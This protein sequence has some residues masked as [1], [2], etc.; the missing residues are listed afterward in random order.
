MNLLLARVQIVPAYTMGR[1]YVNGEPEC[2]VLEDPVRDG[3]KVPGETAI[4]FG[5][6]VITID[7]SNRFKREMPTIKLST[8]SGKSPEFLEKVK[9]QDLGYSQLLSSLSRLE[10]VPLRVNPGMLAWVKRYKD[11]LKRLGV[12][13]TSSVIIPDCPLPRDLKRQD[14]TPMELQKLEEW[15]K[16]KEAALVLRRCH[17]PPHVPHRAR[18]LVP[19]AGAAGGHPQCAARGAGEARA[20]G[21]G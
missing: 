18:G 13:A 1:L 17:R 19:Q 14:M 16:A 15:K 2:W 11:D 12:L 3:P 9:E 6:Y 21:A 7:W 5:T 8:I 20:V 10:G 4:P